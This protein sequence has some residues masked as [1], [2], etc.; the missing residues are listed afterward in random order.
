[1][2]SSIQSALALFAIVLG[3][4]ACAATYYVNVSNTVPASPFATWSTAAT[5]IQNAVDIST[6][7]DLILV[8]NGVYKVGGRIVYGST[9]NRVAVNKAVTVQS[10]NGSGVTLI[11]GYHVSGTTNGNAAVRC[12]YLTNGATL[13]GFTLTNGATRQLGD[14][15]HEQFGGGVWCEGT[16]ACIYNCFITQNAAYNYGGG[17]YCGTLSNCLM[18]WNSGYEGGAACSNVLVNC[19]LADNSASTG[20]GVVLGILLN[21]CLISNN[22]AVF[23]GGGATYSA[24]QNCTLVGNSVLNNT[25][26]GG[27]GAIFSTLTG[28]VLSNNTAIYSYED[29]GG[30]RNSTLNNCALV[31]NKANYLGGGAYN[32]SMLNCIFI[33][34]TATNNGGGACFGTAVN[35]FFLENMAINIGGA[36][37]NCQLFN[38][39][40]ISNT[41]SGS[42][43]GTS[44]RL[45]NCIVYFNTA[46]VDPNYSAG[47]IVAYTC[48]MPLPT[49]G[50]AN[51]TNTP[52]F[53]NLA[54]SD[55]HLQSNSPCINAGANFSV[56]CTNDLDGNP[57]IVG[58]TVDIGAYEYQTPSS[59]LSY[60]WAQQYGLPTDS[61]VDYLD[62]DCTGME[63]WQKSIAGLNPTNPASVL[64]MLP[65]LVT[66]SAT[67]VTVSWQ[68]VNTRIYYLQRATNLAAQ[69]VFSALQSNLVG[70]AGTTS[71]TDTSTTNSNSFFYR[72]GVQ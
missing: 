8:S 68:S 28:C 16:N 69:P 1:V 58:G 48:T 31:N 33:G 43:G 3:F 20:G 47:S 32:C 30:A 56:T 10:V 53:N 65:P 55:Y 35:C 57:R 70:Q 38:C 51:F 49:N 25:G 63:N 59:I 42:G 17:A 7:G 15:T 13:I 5:N 61:S 21:S 26:P 44:G 71:F 22:S 36:A 66:N 29:G 41:A 50:F 64:A 72:V 18:T 37:S 67:G 46:P 19:T 62:L 14:V 52:L 12:V 2:K 39:T 6:N 34:N 4:N 54:G 40:V 60:V 45:T 27:G 23:S 9:S 11:Q 24:L